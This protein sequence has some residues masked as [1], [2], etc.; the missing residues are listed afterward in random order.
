MPHVRPSLS[1]RKRLLFSLLPTVV[2]L[3]GAEL[4]VRLRYFLVHNHDVRYFLVPFSERPGTPP[5]D[6]FRVHSQPGQFSHR[7]SCTGREIAFVQNTQ[8]GRGPEWTR[9]KAGIV[10]IIA[11][12]GSTTYG[13]NNPAEATWPSLLEQELRRTIDRPVEVLNGGRPGA[14][15]DDLLAR[16]PEWLQYHPD[17]L[18]FYEGV[19]STPPLAPWHPDAAVGRFHSAGWGS[20]ASGLYFRSMLY[21]YLVEK[22]YYHLATHQGIQP[23]DALE[24]RYGYTAALGHF[25]STLSRVIHTLKGHQIAP[26]LVLQLTRMETAPGLRT[27]DIGSERAIRDFLLRAAASK[28]PDKLQQLHLV[29]SYAVQV[30]Q[31]AVRRTG[32]AEDVQVIDPRSTFEARQGPQSLEHTD[33]SLFCDGFHLN[34]GGN[35]L[36]AQTIAA[37]LKRSR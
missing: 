6:I 13:V 11:F 31:E 19:N 30:F 34:D 4:V 8:G 28:S 5:P 29:G 27:L 35:V 25:Q 21:T 3:G 37:E 7:D 9:K 18:I 15:V 10:R 32:E 17:T 16:L 1:L 33:T 26:V 24:R 2:F 23:D 12:G 22:F 36:L 20:V 14:K